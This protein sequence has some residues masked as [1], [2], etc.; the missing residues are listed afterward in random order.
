MYRFLM[1]RMWTLILALCLSVMGV[2]AISS[3][4]HADLGIGD[5]PGELHPPD[6]VPPTGSGD[7]DSPANG[8]KPAARPNLSGIRVGVFGSHGTGD[9]SATDQSAWVMRIRLMMH[10]LKAYYLRY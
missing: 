10:A 8:G 3:N 9:A 5:D 1:N 4:A 2:T 7:P 6:E